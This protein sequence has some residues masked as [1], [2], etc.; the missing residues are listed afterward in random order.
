LPQA[1]ERPLK[2]NPGE[3]PQM[4]CSKM[5][6]V[7][8]AG[9]FI[10]V[11]SIAPR[12]SAAQPPTTCSNASVRG[13]YGLLITG[14]DSTG[15]Y[16]MGMGQI[17]S[18]GKGTFTGTETVSDDGTIYDNQA[19]TGTYSISSNCTGS[20]TIKNVKNGTL[21]HYNFVVDPLG[22]QVQAAG[23]DSGHGTA[24]G[25]AWALGTATCSTAAAAGTY[26]FHGGGYLTTGGVLQ[27]DGQYI[28]DGA[29]NLSGIETRIVNGTVISA[30]PITGTYTVASTC[31]GTASYQFSGATV[32]VNI[33][34]VNG[35]KSFFTIETDTGTVSTAVAQQ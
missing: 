17:N 26:G 6:G 35:G 13:L 8:M 23:T 10:A 29:G 1:S 5:Y 2:T 31:Q 9:V 16:Q 32:N 34:M 7:A 4:I 22:K 27:F 3:K 21:S 28:L 30:S 25:Y 24:S 11:L 20:G 19:L 18:T 12:A 15:L 33:V 14:Y